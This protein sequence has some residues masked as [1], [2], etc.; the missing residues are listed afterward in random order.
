MLRRDAFYSAR[1]PALPACTA[2]VSG[3]EAHQEYTFRVRAI[4]ATGSS[5]SQGETFRTAPAAPSSPV[6][7]QQQGCTPSSL[8]ISWLPPLSDHG[9]GVSGYQLESARSSRTGSTSQAWRLAYQGANTQA[10]VGGG[11]CGM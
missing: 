1:L 3:L 2:A 5:T 9:A 7:M 10:Q 11:G 6:G 8:L 4:N